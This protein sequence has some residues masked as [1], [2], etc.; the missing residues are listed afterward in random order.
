MANVGWLAAV[1]LLVASLARRAR[2]ARWRGLAFGCA[3][4]LV[5]VVILSSIQRSSTLLTYRA[6]I[7]S[8]LISAVSDCRSGGSL[9]GGARTRHGDRPPRAVS[10]RRHHVRSGVVGMT[11]QSAVDR[12]LAGRWTSPV[13]T[14]HAVS[15]RVVW[16]VFDELDYQL[17]F[18]ERPPDLYL[19]ELD[20]LRGRRSSR[21]SRSRRG[22][23]ESR[24]AG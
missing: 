17:A 23:D 13:P 16:V 1:F 21:H 24:D 9:A 11:G 15:R 18:G 4:L 10:L 20:R 22:R 7:I 12:E 19:P 14:A 6:L 5:S 2:V 3:A 8:E